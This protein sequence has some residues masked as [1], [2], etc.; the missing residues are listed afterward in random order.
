MSVLFE[1]LWAA[2]TH[3]SLYSS[4]NIEALTVILPL[5]WHLSALSDFVYCNIIQTIII[6]QPGHS[7]K[8]QTNKKTQTLLISNPYVFPYLPWESRT[9]FCFV[10]QKMEHKKMNSG[11]YGI[12]QQVTN[13][14]SLCAQQQTIQVLLWKVSC[15]SPCAQTAS[16]HKYQ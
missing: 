12:W 9:Y 11:L 14:L 13:T 15:H 10:V 6:V 3:F 5:Q 8:T 4:C 2:S 1:Y 7:S 16:Q